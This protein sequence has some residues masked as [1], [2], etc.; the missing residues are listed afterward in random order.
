MAPATAGADTFN[1]KSTADTGP[2]SLRRAIT[3]ANNNAGPDTIRFRI[4]GG[5]VQTIKPAS[6]LPAITGVVT[7]N[8]YSQPGASPNT[9]AQ[10]SDAVL[11]IQLNGAGATTANGLRIE[12]GGSTIRGLVINRFGR[13]GLSLP[14]G[15]GNVVAGNFIGTDASGTARR[16]N[17]DD[18][19]DILGSD[20]NTVGGVAPADR[21][22]LSGNA[23]DGVQVTGGLGTTGNQVA[24][25]YIGTDKTG[26]ADLGNNEAGVLA[27]SVKDSVIGGTASGARNVISGNGGDGVQVSG[28]ASIGVATGNQVLGNFVG[29]DADGSADLGNTE[30]GVEVHDARVNTVG[31]AVA[32]ARNVISGNDGQGVVISGNLGT[33][34]QVLGNYLGTE[35]DGT[36]ALGNAGDGVQIASGADENTIG[37]TNSAALNVISGNEGDGV[38]IVGGLRAANNQ[39]L[40]NHIGT[41][42]DGTA[43]LGNGEDGVH[44]S[45]ESN[46]IGGAAPSARNVISGNVDDGVEIGEDAFS[47]V[48]SGN[49]IGTDRSGTSALGNSG[50]AGVNI[51]SADDNTVGGTSADARNIISGNAGDGVVIFNTQA[52]GNKVQGNF[53]GTD[54]NGAALG[55]DDGVVISSGNDSTIGGAAS[56]AGNRIANNDGDGVIVFGGAAVGN[57]ILSN[58]MFSNNN[59]GVD[60]LG[61]DLA[62]DGVTANDT[63]DPDSASSNNRRQNFPVITAAVKSQTSPFF[64][65][66]SGTLNSN[67]NQSFTIQCFLAAP[68]P[69][70]HGEGQIPLGQTAAT[71]NANGDDNSWSCPATPIPQVGQQVTATATNTATGDTSEFSQNVGVT[72]GP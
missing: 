25:N 48:V 22:V 47:N 70:G 71:T 37:G 64:T 27:F 18:G 66:I 45:A 17:G 72:P 34:N 43:D 7:V 19:V 42:E 67:P 44:I 54:K 10:G 9:L 38:D 12:S 31:G 15:A 3:Q 8:G 49:Y 21:N 1:V 61:I 40:G 28:N 16:G 56:G 52:T 20:N 39:V 65:A 55:N 2:D 13:D 62:S 32:S 23:G 6:A 41:D 24:G 63:D 53:I 69:S 14:S 68:D 51:S 29:T 35:S 11:L 4:P 58:L 26:T 30:S 60:D 57:T 5:G 36:S 59:D 50:D 46:T 33:D